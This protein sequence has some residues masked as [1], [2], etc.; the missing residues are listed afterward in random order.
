MSGTLV[1]DTGPN[2]SSGALDDSEQHGLDVTNYLTIWL[3]LLYGVSAHQII[4]PLGAIGTPALLVAGGGA[5]AWLAS[6]FVS[7]IPGAKGI[8]PMRIALL[9][10]L[11]YIFATIVVAHTRSLTDLEQ[12]GSV[13]EALT[14][15]CLCGLA[16]LV[17]DGVPSLARLDELMRRLVL[18]GALFSLIGLIQSFLGIELVP[19]IPGL[20]ANSSLDA[21]G[22][23]SGFNRPA[24]TALHPIEF[25]VVTAALL[26][27]ALYF[28][29]ESEPGRQR[30][31]AITASLLIGLAIPMSISR[32]GIVVLVAGLAFV[33]LGWSWRERLQGLIVGAMVIPVL[34]L[35]IPGLVGTFES[36]FAGAE[37]DPSITARLERVPKIFDIIRENLWFGLGSGTYSVEDYFLVD[38]EFW[39]STMETGVIGICLTFAVLILGAVMAITSQFHRFATARTRRLGYAI[40]AGIIGLG[41]SMFTFDAFFYH[42]LRGT[43]F[44]LLGSAGAL[45]RLTR[46]GDADG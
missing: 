46:S 37:N 40:A 34:W 10:Y 28:V 1:R 26:P 8:Q 21:I 24:A 38:N 39:V 35:T 30:K 5:G 25:G 7:S 16:F 36:M 18:A 15:L 33:W 3:V 12:T 13:R 42:I 22:A 20:T 44:L 17:M 9:A 6:R 14:L 27:L 31:I 11:W 45:W 23:R 19:T 41:V 29:I 43:L 2:R 4:G 32:S